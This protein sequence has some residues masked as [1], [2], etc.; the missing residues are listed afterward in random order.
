MNSLLP[1]EWI[2][3]I[4]FLREGMAQ[5]LLIIT[6]VSVGVGV[7]VFMSALLN[8][9]QSNFLRRVLSAQAH[10]VLLAPQEAAR[11]LLQDAGVRVLPIVQ[12]RTQRL[13]SIDQW[14]KVRDRMR[15]LPHVTTVSPMASGP[16]FAI[17]GDANKSISLRHHAKGILSTRAFKFFIAGKQFCLNSKPC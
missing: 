4:R 17:R 9:L 12:R 5:T 6:G 8:G 7:I 1:F 11:P 16:A 13:R 3:A 14:I 2:A 15:R 10:I